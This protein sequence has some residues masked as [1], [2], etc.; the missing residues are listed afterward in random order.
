MNLDSMRHA[1]HNIYKAGAEAVLP[2]RG[3]SGF[4]EHGVCPGPSRL[5]NP[6]IHSGQL[7]S[8]S[9]VQVLTPEEFVTAG[10]YLVR[11]CPTWSW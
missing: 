7:R 8:L 1:V 11:T 4:K 10:D 5:K 3:K 6:T 2:V 9:D